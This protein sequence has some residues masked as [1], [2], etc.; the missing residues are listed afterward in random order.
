MW[1]IYCWDQIYITC[2]FLRLGLQLQLLYRHLWFRD[3]K[4]TD[5][6]GERGKGFDLRI[7]SH[8]IH[9]PDQTIECVGV[10]IKLSPQ[11]SFIVLCVYRPPNATSDFYTGLTKILKT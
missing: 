10:T 11:M 6:T 2:V 7:D 5:G 8:Q 4:Y 9:I 1:N 3:I